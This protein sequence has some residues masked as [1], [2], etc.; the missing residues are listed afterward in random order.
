MAN[1][2]SETCI[3]EDCSVRRLFGVAGTRK[4]CA[5]HARMRMVDVMHKCHAQMCDT[6]GCPVRPLYGVKGR[7]KAEFCAQH[8]RAGMVHVKRKKCG[9]KGCSHRG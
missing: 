6:E 7:R 2:A 8:A 1:V 3:T 5:Q 4:F 9:G